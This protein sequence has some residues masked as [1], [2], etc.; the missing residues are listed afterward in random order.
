MD[1]SM[2]FDPKDYFEKEVKDR[3]EENATK[4]FDDLVAK[5][6]TDLDANKLTND[7]IK[8]EEANDKANE[9]VLGRYQVLQGFMIFF[10]ILGG[11][12]AITG[13]AGFI[14]NLFETAT[15]IILLV[16]GIVLL[17]IG[18]LVIFLV[19]KNKIKKLKA[20]D[21]ENDKR[22]NVL[23]NEARMQLSGL[24]D[25]FT[26]YD[27]NNI[28]KMTTN[29]FELDDVL[30]PLK[31]LMVRELYGLKSEPDEDE[32]IVGVMSGNVKTN[33]FIRIKVYEKSMYQ[34]MYTGSI[35]ISWTETV[36]DGKNGTR[37]VTRTQTLTAS[38]S[39]PAPAYAN[40][41]YTI[42]GNEAAPDL[43]FSRQPSGLGIN[44]SDKE[45]EKLTKSGEKKLQKLAEK[46]IS[47][48]GTF[49]PLANTKFESLFGAI[50]RNNETQF[51]LLFTPLAQQNMVEIITKSPFGDDFSFY[52]KNKI[53]IISSLHGREIFDFDEEGFRNILYWETLKK[54]FVQNM[55]DLYKSLFFEMAPVLSIPLYQTTEGGVYDLT[56]GIQHISDYE[57]ESFVNHMDISKFRAEGTSTSQ[58]LK[59]KFKGSTNEMDFF[60]VNSS[61]FKTRNRV[62]YEHRLGGDGRMHTIPVHWVEYIPASKTS[63]VAIKQFN[64]GE[65]DF[66][67]L[68]ESE[69]FKASYKKAFSSPTRYK[70]FIGF[71]DNECYNYDNNFDKEMTEILNK[72]SPLK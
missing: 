50:N 67:N 48:G 53:N 22:L 15:N 35:V 20:I 58:I 24:N 9:A 30:D 16:V 71:Y 14:V 37:T 51:R 26:F 55:C 29:I 19:T 68:K 36:S 6:K 32:S 5:T 13:I 31:L 60:E 34:K 12:L 57:A 52:K 27:F 69:E 62:E 2:Q 70:K 21:S 42:Y 33:P 40:A 18:L 72:F 3:L 65:R 39:R 11:G 47:K 1:E 49:Q 17:T 56:K 23:Y 59:I 54:T 46:S 64:G 41:C 43:S 38:I 10:A 8:K 61:S 66:I 44:P 7:K 4:Y 63:T 28:V 25:A 45:I